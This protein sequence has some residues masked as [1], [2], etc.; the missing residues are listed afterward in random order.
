MFIF[1]IAYVLYLLA[2][3]SRGTFT[4]PSDCF[5]PSTCNLWQ[6]HLGLEKV[7][8][9]LHYKLN[10]CKQQSFHNW[11]KCIMDLTSCLLAL[12]QLKLNAPV[13]L[14]GDQTIGYTHHHSRDKEQNEQQQHVPENSQNG[15]KG[16]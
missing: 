12:A 9:H 11:I 16:V 15:I 3:Y 14:S 1:T 10:Q 8:F 5:L 13:E 7:I 6:P 4:G 2:I